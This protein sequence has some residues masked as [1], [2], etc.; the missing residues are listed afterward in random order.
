[1][2]PMRNMKSFF[3]SLIAL[4]ILGSCTSS[5]EPSDWFAFFQVES[6]SHTVSALEVTESLQQRGITNVVELSEA[7][8]LQAVGYEASVKGNHATVRIRFRVGI[9]QGVVTHFD[10]ISHQEHTGFG[11]ILI[12]ALE[13]KLVGLPTTLTAIENALV[14]TAVPSTALTETYDGIMPALEAMYLHD[15]SRMG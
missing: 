7:N 3:F 15:A 11:V 6:T 12:R 10:V 13:E 2:L 9:S 8:S 5:P 14:T 4:F 1:M